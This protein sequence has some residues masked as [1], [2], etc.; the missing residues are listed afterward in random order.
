[1]KIYLAA[2]LFTTAERQ[3]NKTLATALNRTGG[4]IIFLPQEREPE[5][6]RESE[7]FDSDVSGLDWADAVVAVLDGPDIESGTAWECGYAYAKGKIVIGI[8]T[9]KRAEIN[10]MLRYG[11]DRYQWIDCSNAMDSIAKVINMSLER[12]RKNG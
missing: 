11:V 3:F 8:R 12:A 6:G 5:S 7:I 1:M 10:L 9:D 2:P 4:H